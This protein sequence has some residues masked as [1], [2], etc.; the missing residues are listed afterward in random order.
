VIRFLVL[1]VFV[2]NCQKSFLKRNK[3]KLNQ[4]KDRNMMIILKLG[5]MYRQAW[6]QCNKNISIEVIVGLIS[7]IANNF[8]NKV[9]GLITLKFS[10]HL[11]EISCVSDI[12]HKTDCV[13]D[14][15]GVDNSCCNLL[16]VPYFTVLYC[17]VLHC[18]ELLTCHIKFE[19]PLQYVVVTVLSIH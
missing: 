4:F 15:Y 18:K 6:A 14:N 7:T 19:V 12:L 3:I 10:R 2:S 13:G 8:K 1:F 17:T 9:G 5:N 16:T 11:Q